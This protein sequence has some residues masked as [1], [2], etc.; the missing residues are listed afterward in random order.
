MSTKLVQLHDENG[1][2]IYPVCR[3]ALLLPAFTISGTCSPTLSGGSIQYGNF[4]YKLN[5]DRS[6]GM[7]YGCVF[8]KGAGNTT[9]ITIDLGAT[10]SPAP[11]QEIEIYGPVSTTFNNTTQAE[12]YL[13]R[14]VIDT[15]GNAK[16]KC[17]F[18]TNSATLFLNTGIIRF[19]DFY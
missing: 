6:I 10:V 14:F 17:T 18:S 2:D 16:M 13:P 9:V 11:A 15:S 19:S 4:K 1:N 8:I 5:S 3:D 12:A 7:F